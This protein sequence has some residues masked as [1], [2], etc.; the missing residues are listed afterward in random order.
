MNLSCRPFSQSS[1]VKCSMTPPAAEPALLTMM[2]T[3]PSALA[4]CS[5]KF[6]ASLSWRKSAG[7]ATIL[8]PVALPISAAAASSGSLRRAQIATSTPSFA[9]ASAM[10][11]PMPSEPPVTSAVLPLSLRSIAFLR[12]YFLSGFVREPTAGFGR[13]EQFGER[14]VELRRLLR[15]NVVPGARDHQQ[16]GGRRDAL[17]E[18]AA[19]NAW[20]VLIADDHQQRHRE[21]PQPILHLIKRRPLE[22]QIEHRLRVAFGGMLGQHAGK[23]GVAARILMLLR[24]AHRR[25][26]IFRRSRGNAFLGEHLAGLG[27][28]R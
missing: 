1:S 15:G 11:L 3:R 13:G 10:P 26:G 17:E 12:L 16:P 18:Y 9:K 23:F 20:L 7:M 14:R 4:P 24:V 2:S 25:V 6:L 19:L 22:L 8:R 21:F 5:T 27:S 28:E